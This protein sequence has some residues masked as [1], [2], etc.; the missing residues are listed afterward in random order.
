MGFLHLEDILRLSG[1][2]FFFL[3]VLCTLAYFKIA[4]TVME[5]ALCAVGLVIAL[6]M[7]LVFGWEILYPLSLLSIGFVITY[8]VDL[9]D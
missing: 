7:S 9:K 5:Y 2:N 8:F 1:K 6:L 3:Y 4:R